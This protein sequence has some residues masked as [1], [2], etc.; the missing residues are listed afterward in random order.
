MHGSADF[1]RAQFTRSDMLWL[2]VSVT[3]R[4]NTETIRHFLS[5][6][7]IQLFCGLVFYLLVNHDEGIFA[8]FDGGYFRHIGLSLF[9]TVSNDMI[10]KINDKC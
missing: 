10:V 9:L 1:A 7:D 6:H 5:R 3:R 2:F 8:I 4:I